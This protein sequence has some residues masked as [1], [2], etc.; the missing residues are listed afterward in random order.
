ML[1]DRLQDR[2]REACEQ[3]FG[4]RPEIVPL[5]FPTDR[6]HGDLTVNAFLLA[7][8]LRLRPDAIALQLAGALSGAPETLRAEA[9][10]GFVNL[11]LE[12][13]AL[14]RTA[15]SETL[16]AGDAYGRG[17]S[18]AGTR[19][20]IEFS[21]PNTN[22]PMHLGHMRN[23][24]LGKS[25]ALVRA[26]AGADMVRANLYNDRG[27]QIC[28]S[29]LAYER[30]GENATP[31]ST[32]EKGDHFVGRYYVMFETRFREE[33][34]AWITA[35]PA[36][37]E[38]W[39]ATH[40]TDRKGRPLSADR[41]HANYVASFKE[42]NFGLVTL[43]SDCQE[44]LR[45]WEAGDPAVRELWATMNAWALEGFS[46]T[47]ARLG[48][49]FDCLYRE[50]ETY[51]LGRELVLA[52]VGKG[53]FERLPDGAV[54][55]DLEQ[56]GLGR[57]VVLRSDGT[58][59]YITQDI[60]TTVLKADQQH[61]DGQTWVV[62]EEQ[63]WHFK[64]LFAV[65]RKMGYSWAPNLRHLSYG[66][67][68]LPSG[69]MKSR[70]GT[71]V[72]ADDLLNEVAD[73]AASEIRIRDPDQALP[74]E[75]VGRRAEVIALAALQFMLLKV[76]PTSEMIFNPE[77]SV[78]FEGDTGAR[79]LYAYARL[80]TMILDARAEDLADDAP[81]LVLGQE[82]ERALALRLLAYPALA[83]RAA[84]DDNPS[85]IAAFILDLVRDL[86]RFY[87]TCD[88]LREADPALRRARL[89]LCRAVATGLRN[90]CGLLGMP[91]LERM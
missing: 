89:A 10:K 51:T 81:T 63:A 36:H 88:V 37:E 13:A 24:F 60:G 35:H 74:D 17:R 57:K 56:E 52:G 16:E 59:V 54:V 20:L 25:V 6:T 9:V 87:E 67:V 38:T 62:A 26:N 65:L 75:E 39:A 12:P 15:V 55:C 18:L 40:S 27:I 5:E 2:V 43:G 21:A 14:F 85:V 68:H 84:R 48:I 73:L 29:M 31:A 7:R 45:N 1:L 23:N 77:E 42:E 61:V 69:R 53:T 30:Y 33:R 66:L 19:Q 28:K 70:E 78:K 11:T 91:L 83:G 41:I 76:T 58:S 79:V 82:A 3:L 34:D 86:N 64:V 44:M 32:G 71:V 4:K 50:S 8:E 72:D 90:A 46:A 47:Y 80:N 22:K 49:A